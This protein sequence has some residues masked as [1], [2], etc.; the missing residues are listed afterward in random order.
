MSY[1]LNMSEVDRVE[2]DIL[3]KFDKVITIPIHNEYGDTGF[4][5]YLGMTNI[6][7]YAR[8]WSHDQGT[9]FLNDSATLMDI[10]GR[11]NLAEEGKPPHDESQ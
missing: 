11:L 2:S 8:K 5:I 6:A 4:A 7:A 9:K 10:A 3:C 1:K